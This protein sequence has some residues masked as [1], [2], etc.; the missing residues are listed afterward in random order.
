M[1]PLDHREPGLPGT[2]LLDE[3]VTVGLIPDGI[4]V[5]PEVVA[6]VRRLAG[7]DRL[8]I[9]TD[10]IAAL[11]M[12]P[13]RYRLAGQDVVVDG[14]SARLADGRL[15]GSVIAMDAAVRNLRDFTGCSLEEAIRAATSVPARLLGLEGSAGMV[16]V[17]AP[18]DLVLL[19]ADAEV[20]VTIVGGQVVFERS[21]TTLA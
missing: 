13:G 18:A 11:D 9:V 1:S 6:L 3:R 17:G 8:S 7:P 2:A 19:T 4:H 20:A 21:T 10:A 12:T 16:S 15:A 5:H 14:T